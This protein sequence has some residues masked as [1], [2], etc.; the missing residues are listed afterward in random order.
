MRLLRSVPCSSSLALAMAT[1]F[2]IISFSGAAQ[3]ENAILDVKTGYCIAVQ[4]PPGLA[5][6]ACY[7]QVYYYRESNKTIYICSVA[8]GGKAGSNPPPIAMVPA[9]IGCFPLG[10]S[11]LPGALSMRS[12]GDRLNAKEYVPSG[13]LQYSMYSWRGAYWLASPSNG[14]LT[15][16]VWSNDVTES[17]SALGCTTKIDWN[18]YINNG[19]VGAQIVGK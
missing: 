9:E 7:S 19:D 2:S 14:A 13:N 5:G 17:P 8:V 4:Q 18:K 6:D 3:A 12:L 11:P 1:S 15:F 16:C 10:K